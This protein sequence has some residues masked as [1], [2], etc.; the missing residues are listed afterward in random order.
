MNGKGRITYPDGR[1]YE[2][3]WNH[4]AFHGIGRWEDSHHVYEGEWVEGKV[5]FA[6]PSLLME[7]Q[8]SGY[9]KVVQNWSDGQ[10]FI[11]EGQWKNGKRHGFGVGTF[12]VG[13]QYTGWW[14]NDQVTNFSL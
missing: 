12:G 8:K 1:K 4:G 6:K 7:S 3:E 10:K 14:I 5:M 2:G 9:G 13:G 11:Y